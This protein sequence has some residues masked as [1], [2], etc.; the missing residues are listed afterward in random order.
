M[1]HR[2]FKGISAAARLSSANSDTD[3]G[4][5][6]GCP[7]HRAP[8]SRRAPGARR[9]DAPAE[10][11]EQELADGQHRQHGRE[12]EQDDERG[13]DP[14]ARAAQQEREAP[15]WL[16]ISRPRRH[17]RRSRVAEA[18]GQGRARAGWPI[19]VQRAARR[20]AAARRLAARSRRSLARSSR[21]FAPSRSWIAGT[22]AS[23]FSSKLRG[24]MKTSARAAS[25]ASTSRV[26]AA[27]RDAG[28]RMRRP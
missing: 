21:G 19:A 9:A 15:A 8:R 2:S 6:R 24:S 11:D 17:R 23:S 26:R 16:V 22:P 1:A 20:R 27:I 3:T 14:R 18:P 25:A 10:T 7:R 4:T 28:N 13:Q 5:S 12:G